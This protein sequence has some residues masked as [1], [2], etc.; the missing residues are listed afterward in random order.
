MEPIAA[1]LADLGILPLRDTADDRHPAVVRN[2][3]H[4]QHVA[5]AFAR[6]Q[7]MWTGTTPSWIATDNT[8]YINLLEQPPD[9]LGPFGTRDSAIELRLNGADKSHLPR[10]I[11]LLGDIHWMAFGG[12]G[13][14]ILRHS[15]LMLVDNHRRTYALYDPADNEYDVYH[16]VKSDVRVR[17]RYVSLAD[18]FD[19]LWP[20]YAGWDQCR[21]WH[22]RPLQRVV[23]RFPPGERMPFTVCAPLCVLVAACARRFDY[24]PGLW[25][26]GSRLADIVASFD[27]ADTER[28]RH[29]VAFW[30]RGIVCGRRK[31]ARR[32]VGLEDLPAFLL[33]DTDGRTVHVRLC[34]VNHRGGHACAAPAD[35][36]TGAYCAAHRSALVRGA[37]DDDNEA[38]VI[39]FPVPDDFPNG[40]AAGDA[41]RLMMATTSAPM[42]VEDDD[43]AG[44]PRPYRYGGW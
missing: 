31:A 21:P 20:A 36:P 5:C 13:G 19:H 14:R 32:R 23:D 26:I 17:G 7:C 22:R 39:H 11:L 1:Y 15:F 44:R 10:V 4:T 30:Y 3:L 40:C 28:F 12:G 41:P 33:D 16:P 27:A 43:N 9:R 6:T 2:H 37:D 25:E 42:C 8:V 18:M 35:P 29:A 38:E 24:L 34:G